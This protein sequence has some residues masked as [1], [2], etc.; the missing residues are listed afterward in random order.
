M[1]QFT[2]NFCVSGIV[3]NDATIHDFNKNCLGKFGLSI[4]RTDER[5]ERGY[6][7]AIINCEAWRKPE[8]RWQLEKLKKGSRITISGFFVPNEWTDAN[9]Q[10]RS[11][12]LLRVTMIEDTESKPATEA[13]A[14]SAKPE[15]KADELP[16]NN[17]LFP[18]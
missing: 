2:N 5:A 8:H 16:E 4:A 14:E 3:C 12:V 13:A 11:Q 9:G 7:S 6:V 17:P 18:F 1:A 10:N 15:A